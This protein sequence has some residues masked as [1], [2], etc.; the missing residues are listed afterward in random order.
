MNQPEERKVVIEANEGGL[1][2][3]DELLDA[4]VWVYTKEKVTAKRVEE[5]RLVEVF[6]DQPWLDAAET[7]LNKFGRC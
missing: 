7:I 5:G 4:L 3:L 6:V 1:A 2:L